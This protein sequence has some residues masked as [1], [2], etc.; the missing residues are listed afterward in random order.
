MERSWL[1]F[2]G[3]RILRLDRID[4]E[5]RAE[6]GGRNNQRLDT[7]HL[8]EHP[9]ADGTVDDGKSTADADDHEATS[10]CRSPGFRRY[11][12]RSCSQLLLESASN[13]QGLDDA[14]TY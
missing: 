9:E 3:L 4:E 2:S 6:A 7:A 8:I 13:L 5:R 11:G 10:E 14:A 1:V 12:A